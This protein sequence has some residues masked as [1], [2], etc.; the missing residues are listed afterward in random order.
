[1]KIG[2]RQSSQIREIGRA[3]VAA[4]FRALDEQAEVLG[5]SRSTTWTILRAS[6]K[7]SGLSVSTIDRMLAAPR[8]P[9]PVRAKIMEYIAQRAAGSYGDTAARRRKFAARLHNQL[10]PANG[11]DAISTGL[12]GPVPATSAPES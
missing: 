6:H 9:A 12:V 10:T 2:E 4:G 3:L 1:M 5:L 8:L 7:G 11:P